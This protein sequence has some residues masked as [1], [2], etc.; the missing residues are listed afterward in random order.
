MRVPA[1][2]RHWFAVL[3]YRAAD[4][5]SSAEVA[6]APTAAICSMYWPPAARCKAFAVWLVAS[7]SWLMQV[8]VR[9][10]HGQAPC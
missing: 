4:D 1:R 5:G 3:S 7:L 9:K 2:E 10:S 6:A 8:S